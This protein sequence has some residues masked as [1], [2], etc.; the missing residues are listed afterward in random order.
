[1]CTST[2]VTVAGEHETGLKVKFTIPDF[3]HL[4]SVARGISSLVLSEAVRCCLPS[5][6]E[7]RWTMSK[8]IGH[9][10]APGAQEPSHQV[11]VSSRRNV[12]GKPGDWQG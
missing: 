12:S 2:V 4:L 1:M 7:A 10:V 9:L 11:L 6:R 3:F 8:S 5:V